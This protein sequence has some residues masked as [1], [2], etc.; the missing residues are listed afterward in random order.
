MK[1]KMIF[2]FIVRRLES[3]RTLRE[4]NRIIAT[5]VQSNH[6]K[7]KSDI[8][9]SGTIIN[10]GFSS[11]EIKKDGTQNVKRTVHWKQYARAYRPL[12]ANGSTITGYVYEILGVR[13]PW[14]DRIERL[15]KNTP[16]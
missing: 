2:D 5:S 14:Q 1:D 12:D 10:A 4:G 6:V 8:L 9:F 16:L 15:S 13:E 3:R 11:Y 7:K